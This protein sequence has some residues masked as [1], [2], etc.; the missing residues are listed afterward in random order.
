M[1]QTLIAAVTAPGNYPSAGVVAA[2]AAADVP[3]GNAFVSTGRELVIAFNSDSS[4]HNVTITS[5]PDDKGRLG[6][7]VE[8]I[9]AGAYRIYGPLA[10]TAWANSSGNTLISADSALVKFAIL[11]MPF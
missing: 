11:Q 9:A 7:I 4:S 1:S 8:A 5:Q 10:K 6:T 2:F 3:N